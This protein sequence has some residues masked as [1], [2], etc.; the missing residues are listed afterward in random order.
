MNP[1]ASLLAD[2]SIDQTTLDFMQEAR[3]DEDFPTIVEQIPQ[4]KPK[5]FM[6]TVPTY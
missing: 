6:A 5:C 1:S 2:A 4:C 3:P